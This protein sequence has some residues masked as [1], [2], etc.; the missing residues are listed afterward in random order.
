MNRM[1]RV[2]GHEKVRVL[3]GGLPQWRASG[4]DVESSDSGAVLKATAASQAVEMVYHG[5]EVSKLTFSSRNRPNSFWLID[6]SN[7]FNLISFRNV[8]LSNFTVYFE[9]ATVYVDGRSSNFLLKL[10]S[11]CSQYAYI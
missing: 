5:K 1:F 10:S 11:S 3:D 9:M 4:F 8:V 2:F 6:C 7:H